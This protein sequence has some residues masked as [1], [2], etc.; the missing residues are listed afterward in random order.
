ML[1]H[2]Q[3]P[4]Q[5]ALI[6]LRMTWKMRND[7]IAMPLSHCKHNPASCR[8]TCNQNAFNLVQDDLP[9]IEIKIPL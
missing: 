6:T 9:D 5:D 8:S 7:Q 4:D 3:I 1:S 2:L